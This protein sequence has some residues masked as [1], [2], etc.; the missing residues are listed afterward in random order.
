MALARPLRALL[1]V[2][3]HASHLRLFERDVLG[4]ARH[5]DQHTIVVHD[6][7][8]FI[9]VPIFVGGVVVVNVAVLGRI[10]AVI[11]FVVV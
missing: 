2:L 4:D 11:P 3:K 8:V 6:F 7:V 1:E 9:V 5:V 10:G